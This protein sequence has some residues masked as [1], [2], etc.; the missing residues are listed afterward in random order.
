MATHSWIRPRALS[1]QRQSPPFADGK[2]VEKLDGSEGAAKTRGA[3][4]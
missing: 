3:N 2:N 1:R 4:A